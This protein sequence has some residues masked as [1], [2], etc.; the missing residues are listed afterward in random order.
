MQITQN[1]FISLRNA[2]RSGD[3]K[4]IEAIVQRN[5]KFVLSDPLNKEGTRL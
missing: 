5:G 1:D 3:T 2:V 4:A